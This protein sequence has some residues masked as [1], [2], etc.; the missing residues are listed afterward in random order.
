MYTKVV[1]QGRIAGIDMTKYTNI[2][3]GGEGLEPAYYVAKYYAWETAG[4]YWD[5]AKGNDLSDKMKPG[6]ATAEDDITYVVNQYTSKEG[7]RK[8]RENYLKLL[9]IIP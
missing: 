5:V 1:E 3:N 4:Y 9:E 6:D 8:R 7:Y 2:V